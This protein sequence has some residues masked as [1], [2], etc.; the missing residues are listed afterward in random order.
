MKL[1]SIPG[2]RGALGAS[3]TVLLVFGIRLLPTA[4]LSG[5]SCFETGTFL[6]VPADVAKHVVDVHVSGPACN[7]TDVVCRDPEPE[8]CLEHWV[9]TKVPGACH[10][11][12]A[13]DDGAMFTRD[14]L[15]EDADGCMCP[16]LYPTPIEDTQIDV[17]HP[18]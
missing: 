8:G 11:E 7:D 12:I 4:A 9:N 18:R 15:I 14:V 1:R 17:T 16:G 3:F 13:F 10:I 6:V 5:C 2:P